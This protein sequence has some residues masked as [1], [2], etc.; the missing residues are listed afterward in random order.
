MDDWDPLSDGE[1]EDWE[2][3]SPEN[4]LNLGAIPYTRTERGDER[5]RVNA[6]F[7]DSS[8]DDAALEEDD[9]PGDDAKEDDDVRILPDDPD[10]DDEVDAAAIPTKL[11]KLVLTVVPKVLFTAD[12]YI[13]FDVETT[14]WSK[15]A[16]DIIRLAGV[17]VNKEGKITGTAFNKLISTTRCISKF[18]VNLHGITHE[19][20]KAADGNFAVLG[21]AF[22]SWIEEGAAGC[23]TLCLVAHNGNACDY[24]FLAVSL[25]EHGLSLQDRFKWL[26]LDTLAVIRGHKAF[27][28]Y[29]AAPAQWSKRCDGRPSWWNTKHSGVDY[30]PPS[31]T[32]A[33]TRAAFDRLAPMEDELKRK[34]TNNNFGYARWYQLTLGSTLITRAIQRLKDAEGTPRAR[35]R[36][37]TARLTACPSAAA[38]SC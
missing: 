14:G 34:Y 7:D 22:I 29:D 21:R 27:D 37:S 9:V 15:W 8:S 23:E 35:V 31:I 13:A 6:L 5:A 25:A 33:N 20:L 36:A 26:T 28:Y 10:S 12:G 19:K 30:G 38:P 16:S 2:D 18:D 3:E 24:R 4:D 17:F 32:Q 11:P 1:G